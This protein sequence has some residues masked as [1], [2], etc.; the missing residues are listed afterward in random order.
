MVKALSMLGHS[1]VDQDQLGS[2]DV[3]EYEAIDWPHGEWRICNPEVW[4]CMSQIWICQDPNELPICMFKTF[5]MAPR[6]LAL[7]DCFTAA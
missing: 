5:T 6:E 3:N 7:S 2:M 1:Q 4:D